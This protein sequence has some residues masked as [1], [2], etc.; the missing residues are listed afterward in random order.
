MI[1][2]RYAGREHRYSWAMTGQ[3]GWFLFDGIVK[4]DSLTG[5]EK[6]YPFGDGVFGSETPMAP[7]GR[8]HRRGRRL[9]A[10]L[11]HRREPRRAPRR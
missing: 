11:H 9:P 3:P 4:H 8:R 6:R 5:A 1:N 2:G 10:D 7:A